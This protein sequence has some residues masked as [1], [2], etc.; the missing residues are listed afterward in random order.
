MCGYL[1]SISNEVIDDVDF[2][3]ANSHNICRGPDETIIKNVNEDEFSFSKSN[4]KNLQAFNR[5]AIVE[6]S[7]LGSQPM[8]SKEYKTSIL[9]N[10]EIFNHLELRAELEKEG[11]IFSSKNSDTE[12]LLLGL[13]KYGI[14]FIDKLIGQF[15]ITFFD[16]SKDSVYLIRD[17][18]GQKPLFYNVSQKSLNVSTNLKSLIHLDSNYEIDK[19]SIFE[20]LDIGVVSSPN[21][22]FKNIFKV[23]PGEII[24]FKIS[25][26]ITKE[27]TKKY[28]SLEKF[29][30]NNEFQKNDFFKILENSVKIRNIADVPVA[31]FLSGGIDSSTI[32]KML[33][34]SNQNLN[35]F[36]VSHKDGKY[37]ESYCR[38]LKVYF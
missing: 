20:Y 8:F 14:N 12:V 34:D 10:G 32:V 24:K 18:L 19:N 29:I 2:D 23:K 13:S 38:Y 3:K 7:N 11:L 37:D 6:L 16:Y 30:D 26:N 33:S 35:T 36:S 4:Y 28:W 17:R 27:F 5:L 9:F 22:L 21:T 25:E 31:C 15:S 1:G